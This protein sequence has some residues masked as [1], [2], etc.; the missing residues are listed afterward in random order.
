MN[1]EYR[2]RYGLTLETK[3]A[4]VAIVTPS[5]FSF[6]KNQKGGEW[7]RHSTRVSQANGLTGQ[8]IAK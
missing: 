7:G 5:H 3:Q 6:S 2:R 8:T 4:E 1:R